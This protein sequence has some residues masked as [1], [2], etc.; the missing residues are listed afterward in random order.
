MEQVKKADT[1]MAA[2]ATPW[3]VKARDIFNHHI[4]STAWDAFRFRDSDIVIATYPKSG[5][6]WAQQIVS[7]LLFNGAEGVRIRNH[8]AWIEMRIAPLERAATLE[9][10][11][12]RR[13]LKTHLPVD[14]VVFS[15]RAKYLC[16]GR[17]GRDV[18]WSLY[19]YFSNVS[20]DYLKVFNTA[21]GRKGPPIERITCDVREFFGRWLDGDEPFAFSLWEH[22]RS[23]WN[24]R[25]L[26]NVK[27]FHFNDMK[28]DL[29]G[30]VRAM[31]RFLDIEVNERVFPKIV[32]H[33]TFDYMKARADLVA[34]SAASMWRGGAA[35]FFQKGANGGWCG[36]LGAEEVAAYEARAL[37]ELGPECARW[38][39]HGGG[40]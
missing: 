16:I 1:M 19:N 17:D 2:A 40:T 8:S 23:W 29:A 37:A 39:A 3:P 35:T 9:A 5:T 11:T 12:H 33:C 26:P 31:A 10:Q 15:P 32:E 18:A 14:A 28:A 13:F 27:L 22:A 36:I 6:T 21:P 30:S 7:Q 38:L 25:Q 4:D 34:P 20:D 24:V